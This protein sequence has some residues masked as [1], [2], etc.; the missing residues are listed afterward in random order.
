MEAARRWAGRVLGGWV[1]LF[2]AFDTAVKVV[3]AQVAVDGT[4]RLGYPADLVVIIGIIELACVTLYAIPRTS[5][6]GALLLTAYLGGATAT[7]VRVQ[8]PWFLFP[9]AVGVMSWAALW[10]R[11]RRLGAFLFGT[12]PAARAVTF[13]AAAQS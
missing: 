10:L 7:Q 1:I 3:N 9:V 12:P 11:D 5:I 2:L 8:D 13:A 6:I 4:T